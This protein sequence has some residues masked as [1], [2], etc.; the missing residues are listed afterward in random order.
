[1][2]SLNVRKLSVLTIIS[3]VV[4]MIL[5]IAVEIYRVRSE[6][7]QVFWLDLDSEASFGTWLS[8]VM[9][10]LAAMFAYELSFRKKIDTWQWKLFAL[11]LLGLSLDDELAIHEGTGVLTEALGLPTIGGRDWLIW[12]ILVL[13]AAIVI[14]AR[15]F[16][17]LPRNVQMGLLVGFGL[18][19]FGAFG[20]EGTTDTWARLTDWISNGYGN[21]FHFAVLIEETFEMVGIFV[22]MRT[23]AL[24]LDAHKK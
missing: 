18:F 4:A 22:I 15:F 10:L 14:F 24:E 6:S 8:V 12:G 23:L 16:T 13:I 20:V 1:M 21:K 9:M 11:F 3:I 19:F 7:T 2:K 17:R 5:H